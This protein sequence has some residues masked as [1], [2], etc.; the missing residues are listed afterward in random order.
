MTPQTRTDTAEATHMD[1]VDV[2]PDVHRAT[3]PDEEQIL[4]ELYGEPDAEG[5]FRGE[6]LAGVDGADSAGTGAAGTGQDG[7][8]QDGT[9]QDG[10]G[11]DGADLGG[12]A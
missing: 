4:R 6:G 11:Q 8:G 3:E 9:G 5:I 1:E 12:T 7:T 10:T 2:N